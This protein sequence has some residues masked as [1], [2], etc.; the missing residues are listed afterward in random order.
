M[1][2]ESILH[3]WDEDEEGKYHLLK[4]GTIHSQSTNSL[5]CLANGLQFIFF[6]TLSV[7]ILWSPQEFSENTVEP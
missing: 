4:L 6:R 2:I 1:I 7:L 3:F 5:S